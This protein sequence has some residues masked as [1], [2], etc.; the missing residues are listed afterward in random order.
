[1]VLVYLNIAI[2]DGFPCL[3]KQVRVG[4]K[5][6]SFEIYKFR[7]MRLNAETESGVTWASDEDPRITRMGRFLRKY[8]LDELPQFF[9]ILIGDMS[10]IGPRPERPEFV[11]KLNKEIKFYD[12]RHSVQP[13]LTGW[14]QVCYPYGA[15]V[16]DSRDKLEY[17]LYY[18]KNM[19]FFMDLRVCLKTIGVILL[20]KERNMHVNRTS[21]KPDGSSIVLQIHECEPSEVN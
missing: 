9:N 12:E 16:S 13:G 7:T 2:F 18:L 5:G 15:S 11:E 4:R 8:R 3:Y 17:D 20:G 19:S 10:V 14:A 21:D 1:M 6:K